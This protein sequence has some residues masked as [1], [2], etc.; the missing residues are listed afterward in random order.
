MD[1][2][3]LGNNAQFFKFPFESFV[4]QLEASSI[5]AVD[6]TLLVPHI[7]VDSN[8]FLD[9]GASDMLH[10][11]GIQ[12]FAITPMPY[13]YSI[14]A[15]SDSLQR[16]KTLDYYYQ[17]IQY[18]VF[19]GAKYVC[20]TGAGAEYDVSKTVLLAR[21]CEMLGLLAEEA[22]KVGITLL[23]GAVLGHESPYNETTPVLVNLC[24]IKRV[25]QEVNSPALQVYLDTMPMSLTGET[26]PQ[27]FDTFGDAIHL[28][29]Y[30][31]GNYNGYR[32][33]GQGCFP[34][35]KYL[36]QL[37]SCGYSGPL[38]LNIPGERYSSDPKSAVMSNLS[39]LRRAME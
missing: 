12:V 34:C 7:Y 1:N 25:F 6:L 28:V 27:W 8:E 22:R 5:I 3:L 15:A 11:K 2:L 26:I 23:I 35:K 4:N 38:S 36:D 17:C 16:K 9:C 21:A 32:L 20:I 24:D 29:R 14:C 33:W 18:A 13:R 10:E 31:D 19:C 37:Q 30:V 39:V